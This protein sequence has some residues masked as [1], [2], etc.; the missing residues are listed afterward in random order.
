MTPCI[1]QKFSYFFLTMMLDPK[2][3]DALQ[4]AFMKMLDQFPGSAEGD[5]IQEDSAVEG[6]KEQEDE[7]EEEEEDE[8][9]MPSKK[10]GG[11]LVIAFGKMRGK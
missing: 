1:C 8:E 5:D 4:K 2:Q 3:K 11:A 7:M 6:M 10:K 9:E